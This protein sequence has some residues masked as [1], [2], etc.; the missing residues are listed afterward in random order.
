MPTKGFKTIT[1]SEQVYNELE[2]LAR[3]RFT[4]IPKIVEFLIS[5]AKKE[6]VVE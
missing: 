3:E 6:S 2:K 1:V 4:T 5:K